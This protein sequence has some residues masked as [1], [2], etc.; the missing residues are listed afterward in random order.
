MSCVMCLCLCLWH[1]TSIG[2]CICG[3]AVQCVIRSA[4]CCV[5]LRE[6]LR[7]PRVL[8]SAQLGALAGSPWGL[9]CWGACVAK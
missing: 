1:I 5:L 6:D 4:A 3:V 2:I 9:L 8:C 7:L